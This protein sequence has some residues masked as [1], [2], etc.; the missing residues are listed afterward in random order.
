MIR[1]EKSKAL[2]T[3]DRESGITAGESIREEVRT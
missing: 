1:Q 2:T 3:E